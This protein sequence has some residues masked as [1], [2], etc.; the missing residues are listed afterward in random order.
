VCGVHLALTGTQSVRWDAAPSNSVSVAPNPASIVSKIVAL[1]RARVATDDVAIT[2]AT[3][4][5]YTGAW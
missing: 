4:L 5:R 3:R 2:D 1:N